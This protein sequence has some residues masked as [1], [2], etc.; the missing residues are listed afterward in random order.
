MAYDNAVLRSNVTGGA[1]TFATLPSAA[2]MQ[3]EPQGILAY[4]TDQGLCYW[5]GTIWVALSSSTAIGNARA[6]AALGAGANNNL[7]PVVAGGG[8]WPTNVGRLY[9]TAGSGA[10]NVTGL[11]AGVDGQW[12]F[13]QNVDPA[14][15]VTLNSLNAGSISANQ[16]SY[17]ADLILPP[18]AGALLV[19]DATFQKWLI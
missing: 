19:Y 3:S 7:V 9:F 2:A 10:A 12:V 14:N 13:S 6:T 18:G 5:N 4:T 11:A 17:V 16:F 15:N 8:S 1:Y